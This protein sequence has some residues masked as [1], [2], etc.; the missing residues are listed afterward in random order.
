M[1]VTRALWIPVSRDKQGKGVTAGQGECIL[2]SRRMR[3]S[4]YPVGRKEHVQNQEIHLG[5][6]WYPVA[7]LNCDWMCEAPTEK[8]VTAKGSDISG[9]KSWVTSP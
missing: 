3:S 6:S 4:F 1:V 7:P 5:L 8:D 9:M 2:I